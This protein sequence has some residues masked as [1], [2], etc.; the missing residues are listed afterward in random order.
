MSQRDLRDLPLSQPRRLSLRQIQCM[1]VVITSF[2]FLLL[3]LRSSSDKTRL[4][5]LVMKCK[6]VGE[7][8]FAHSGP[9]VWNFLPQDMKEIVKIDSYKKSI[10]TYL[11]QEY[12]M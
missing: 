3:I 2:T 6:T 8:S 7:R 5:P 12:S 9:T 11:F 10:K 1:L 4:R